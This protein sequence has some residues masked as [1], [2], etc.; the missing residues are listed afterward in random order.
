MKAL[1]RGKMEAKMR[2]ALKRTTCSTI[3]GKCAS[4]CVVVRRK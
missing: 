2:G 4:T 1:T 3:S